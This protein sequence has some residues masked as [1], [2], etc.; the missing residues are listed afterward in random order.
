VNYVEHCKVLLGSFI[1]PASMF[2]FRPFAG[3][4][5]PVCS[6]GL[7][8]L[9][10]TTT[11]RVK[12]KKAGVHLGGRCLSFALFFVSSDADTFSFP[13]RQRRRIQYDENE[14]ALTRLTLTNELKTTYS[15]TPS[16]PPSS[17]PSMLTTFPKS[18]QLHQQRFFTIHFCLL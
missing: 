5:L 15:P 8:G 7:V 2:L 13:R 9:K 17:R 3:Y 11:K 12:G 18:P 16:R 1:P 14:I 6:E 10:M 4:T